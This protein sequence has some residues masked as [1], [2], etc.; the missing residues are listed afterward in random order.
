VLQSQEGNLLF[1]YV[2][3]WHNNAIQ[4]FCTR[5]FCFAHVE[6]CLVPVQWHSGLF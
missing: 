1:F 2:I 5:H 3:V 6:R 4:M